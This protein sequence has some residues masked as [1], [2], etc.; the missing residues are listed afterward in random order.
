VRAGNQAARRFYRSLGAREEDVRQTEIDGDA[1]RRLAAEGSTEHL[2]HGD[3]REPARG[4]E[5]RAAMLR[6]VR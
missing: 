1:L 4:A 5:V 6:E 2:L 3:R